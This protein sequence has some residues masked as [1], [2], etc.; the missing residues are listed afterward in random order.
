[1]TI[2][3]EIERDLKAFIIRNRYD[4]LCETTPEI[5]AGYLADCM[6]DFLE[7]NAIV[8]IFSNLDTNDV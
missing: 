3:T 1:M 5:L 8:P 7:L 4:K 2:L 6:E